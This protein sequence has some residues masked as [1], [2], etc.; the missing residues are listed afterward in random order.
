MKNKL[1]REFGVH[2]KDCSEEFER[3]WQDIRTLLFKFTF[4]GTVFGAF[5]GIGL[6]TWVVYYPLPW[7]H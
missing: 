1:F 7:W 6:M 5:V 3:M 4:W 2:F